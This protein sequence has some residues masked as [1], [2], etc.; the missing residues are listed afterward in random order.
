MHDSWNGYASDTFYYN[1]VFYALKGGYGINPQ[2]KNTVFDHNCFYGYHSSSE[3]PD[4]HKLTANPQFVNPGSGGIGLDTL[5]GYRLRP[6]SP[7]VDAGLKMDQNGGRD[8]WGNPAPQGAGLDLGAHEFQG[9]PAPDTRKPTRPANLRVEECA[10]NRI[11]IAW[12]S[13]AD[14]T[15]IEFYE[16]RCGSRLAGTTRDTSFAV[17]GLKPKTAYAITVTA[18][19]YAGNAAGSKEMRVTTKGK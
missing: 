18:V 12:D 16:I 8:F 6:S 11:V 10:A 15:G 2:S 5:D 13:C 19:D 1:N 3:P 14:D 9:A 7:C 17:D 4:A